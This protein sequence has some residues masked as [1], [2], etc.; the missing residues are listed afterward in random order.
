MVVTAWDVLG[1]QE[2]TK[3]RRWSLSAGVSSA[4]RPPTSWP[5]RRTTWPPPTDV[6]LLE[7]R[8]EI[9]PDSMADQ[10]SA[11]GPTAG[12]GCGRYRPGR[13]QRDSRRRGGIRKRRPGGN[14]SR[15]RVRGSGHGGESWT[16][17]RRRSRQGGRGPRDRRCGVPAQ[18]LEATAG[19]AAIGRQI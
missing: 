15:C 10:A 5:C 8:E 11:H 9:A 6:T 3:A 1:G 17:C 7:M 13:S 19:G 18:S 12:E 14:H 16:P 2:A 4:V